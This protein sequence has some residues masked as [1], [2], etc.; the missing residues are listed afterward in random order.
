MTHPITQGIFA[1]SL[2]LSLAALA[3]AY[4]DVLF[5]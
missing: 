1:I 4:F 3:L 5:I 2:G